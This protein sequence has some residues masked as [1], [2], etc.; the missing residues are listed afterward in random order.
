MR[1]L[2]Y[3]SH[4]DTCD[5]YLFLRGS[6]DYLFFLNSGVPR[7]GQNLFIPI[8]EGVQNYYKG[9]HKMQK[10]H[11]DPGFCIKD[12][13]KNIRK[14]IRSFLFLSAELGAQLAAAMAG[15]GD[16]TTCLQSD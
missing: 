7:R 4:V 11:M 1:I 13:T 8:T 2:A 6:D 12:P 15:D 3:R 5:D 10:L 16:R 14:A 9:P